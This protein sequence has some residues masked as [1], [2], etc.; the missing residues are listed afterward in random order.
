MNQPNII[1]MKSSNPIHIRF[2][3]FHELKKRTKILTY[4][5]VVNEYQEAITF[6][7]L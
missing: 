3:V 5:I 2:E 4:L 1:T 7:V 6:L